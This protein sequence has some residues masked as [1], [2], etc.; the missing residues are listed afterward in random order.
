[1]KTIERERYPKKFCKCDISMKCWMH[2]CEHYEKQFLSYK[3]AHDALLEEK[4]LN[5]PQI[6]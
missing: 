4:N 5:K 1:M 2:L 6:V 3:K